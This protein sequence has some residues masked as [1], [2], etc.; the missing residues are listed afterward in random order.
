MIDLLSFIE[1]APLFRAV[2]LPFTSDPDHEGRTVAPGAKVAITIP[3][4]LMAFFLGLSLDD[5][6]SWARVIASVGSQPLNVTHA[7]WNGLDGIEV[8]RAGVWRRAPILPGMQIRIE[9]TNISRGPLEFRGVIH[10]EEPTREHE[11]PE[12]VMLAVR[13][14][15]GQPRGESVRSAL[16]LVEQNGT[17]LAVLPNG[18]GAV[19][20]GRA[21]ELERMSGGRMSGL[22]RGYTAMRSA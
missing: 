12:V 5:A 7:G 20:C 1:C 17:R 13:V 22:D 14:P 19:V 18:A 2:S 10:C 3:F 11:D 4:Q 21:S 8:E 15:Q 9:A 6:A 16:E